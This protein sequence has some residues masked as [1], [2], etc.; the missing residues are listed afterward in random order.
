MLIIGTLIVFRQIMY[1]KDRPS[2]YNSD[3]LIEVNMRTP[4]I[5]KNYDALRTELINSRYVKNVAR[6]MG[7]VTEDYGGT[8]AVSWKGKTPDMKPLLISNRATHEYGKT[9]GW[10]LLSGRD[11]SEAFSTDTSAVILNQSAA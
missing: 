11:F 6:S 4:E 1:A 7:S 9:I 2:G 5:R 10:K 8:T 3:G